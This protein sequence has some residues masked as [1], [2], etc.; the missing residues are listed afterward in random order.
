MTISTTTSKEAYDGNDIATTF[1]YNFKIEEAS[2]LE[3]ILTDSDDNNT[4]LV[5]NTDYAVSGAGED[6][7]GNVEYPISGDPLATD[8]VITI[9]R[10]VEL[11]QGTDLENQGDFSGETIEDSFD[12]LTMQTQQLQ[13]QLDRAIKADLGS[14]KLDLEKVNSITFD[15]GTTQQSAGV[16]SADNLSNDDDTNIKADAVN[17]GSGDVLTKIYNTIATKIE[18][19]TKNLILYFN[20]IVTKGSTFNNESG[21]NDFEVKKNTSGT[22]YKYDA[23]DDEH[24][25]G[26]DVNITQDLDVT[27]NLSAGT[28]S[29]GTISETFQRIH[30]DILLNAET[31]VDILNLDGNTDLEYKLVVKIVSNF[32]GGQNIFIRFNG[33]ASNTYGYQLTESNGTV[34]VGTKISATSGI[35]LANTQ[36]VDA[37]AM[38]EIIISADTGVIPTV[39]AVTGQSVNN[40]IGPSV[41]SQSLI[42]GVWTN[43]IDNITSINIVG[44][45][46]GLGIGTRIE[47]Y[48]RRA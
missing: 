39:R 19:A 37:V 45:L 31:S 33:D 12:Y 38:S 44:A 28:F 3:V 24:T 10:S 5:L 35:F 25:F 36:I 9:N 7:G 4:T 26:S 21:D 17:D 40:L 41:G 42:G 20:L 18:N 30:S 48:A 8:E 14:G 2:D 11:L 43:S 6:I 34:I 13:E 22:A 29:A 23:G 16:G 15:D 27:N 32:L 46:N 47:L 1:A